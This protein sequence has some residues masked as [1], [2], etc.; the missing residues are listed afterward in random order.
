MDARCGFGKGLFEGMVKDLKPSKVRFLEGS[1]IDFTLGFGCSV[2]VEGEKG[3]YENFRSI[4][5]ELYLKLS[6]EISPNDAKRQLKFV[7][8][9]KDLKANKIK[10]FKQNKSML[11]EETTLT[12]MA[13][14]GLGMAKS[15]AQNLLDIPQIGYPT[16]KKCTGLTLLTP[17]INIHEGF[18]SLSTDLG[19]QAAE[20]GCNILEKD[21]EEMEIIEEANEEHS[22]EDEELMKEDL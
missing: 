20:T 5:I 22:H 16:L 18:I 10:I 3:K 15:Q 19:I 11:V 7:G 21:S 6:L 1:M 8:D 13:N 2:V 17:T 9:V 12:M 14:L 4:Y